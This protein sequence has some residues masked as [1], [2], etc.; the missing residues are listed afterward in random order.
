M[1]NQVA[2]TGRVTRDARMTELQSNHHLVGFTVAVD[3]RKTRDGVERTDFV[4]CQLWNERATKLFPYITQ[5]LLIGV[6]GRIHTYR[7]NDKDG[8]AIYHTV[9]TVDD[10]I[11]LESIDSTNRRSHRTKLKQVNQSGNNSAAPDPF[12][13][14]DAFAKT[15]AKADISDDDLPF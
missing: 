10:F 3:A 1:I 2:L 8:N 4:E 14:P 7:S 15:G 9:V 11:F 13:S 5:G 12:S 6:T